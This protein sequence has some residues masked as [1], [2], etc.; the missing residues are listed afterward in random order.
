VHGA[1]L[2][3]REMT[4]IDGVPVTSLTPTM[5]DLARTLPIEQAV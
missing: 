2:D 3:P 5:L 4:M 1:P